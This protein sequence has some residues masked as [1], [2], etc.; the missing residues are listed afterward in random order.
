[1]T[2]D[3]IVGPG[4]LDTERFE[5]EATMPPQTTKTQFLEMF[6]NLFADRFKI[7][8][9]RENRES[10]T[11]S[12]VVAK[13]GLKMNGSFVDRGDGQPVKMP[14]QPTIIHLTKIPVAGPPP[15]IWFSVTKRPWRS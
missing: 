1:V 3:Q 12:L 13:G 15:Q 11:Y 6:Q 8:A 10:S 9:H 14:D 5:I 4:W 2:N 7:A